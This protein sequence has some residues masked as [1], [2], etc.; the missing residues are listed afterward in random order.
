MRKKRVLL[1][2]WE[3]DHRPEYLQPFIEISDSF[4]FIQLIYKNKEERTTS[5][6][7]LNM[8]Y[9]HDYKN[10]QD[11]LRSV[12]PELIIGVTESIFSAALIN[13]SKKLKIPYY[14]LQHG[15]TPEAISSVSVDGRKYTFNMLASYSK[16][17]LFFLR[18]FSV[19][20]PRKF[21]SA[22]FFYWLYPK[23]VIQKLLTEHNFTW[24]APDF[25]ICFSPYS[26]GHYKKM[27]RMKEAQIKYIGILW[28]D[29]LF[30]N[31]TRLL[32][33]KDKPA[34]KYYLL[35]DTCFANYHK[36]IS[37]EQINHCY[38]T[39]SDFCEKHDAKLLVKL[40]PWNYT[41]ADLLQHPNIEYVTKIDDD[42]LH[43]MI[44]G[45]EGCFGFF[46]TL[47]L[48]VLAFKPMIQIDYDG[49]HLKLAKEKGLTPVID[50]YTFTENDIRFP[51]KLVVEQHK[52]DLNYLVYKTD[53]HA[54]Q[55]L[56]EI[57]LTG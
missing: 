30:Q 9:W 23:T 6:S 11:V 26:A 54:T 50:F 44:A 33:N 15:Y 45:S 42:A 5:S 14:G 40:H 21:C 25:Y 31:F 32:Q 57:L 56:K 46:S 35:I 37:N 8:I 36:T 1:I 13:A 55:R 49:I 12:K 53:G 47:I 4:E 41:K 20:N 7:P 52:A 22:V 38:K 43:A 29:K 19:F 18:S 10:A 28:F 17:T 3:T 27:Y 16:S 2:W 51:E 34:K 39:L 48:P 24:L